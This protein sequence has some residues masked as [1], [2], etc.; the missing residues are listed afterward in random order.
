MKLKFDEKGMVKTRLKSSLPLTITQSKTKFLRLISG[1]IFWALFYS[2]FIAAF[3][4]A[5]IKNPR[6]P[7]GVITLLFFVSPIVFFFGYPVWHLK[8]NLTGWFWQF[9]ITEQA[10]VVKPLWGDSIS[11]APFDIQKY[12]TSKRFVKLKTATTQIRF[13]YRPLHLK[14]G[15]LLTAVLHEW[16]PTHLFPTETQEALNE[17]KTNTKEINSFL[18]EHCQ[19]EYGKK[20]RYLARVVS[21]IFPLLFFFLFPS[22]RKELSPLTIWG[23]LG[24]IFFL[25]L[26]IGIV[27]NL[28]LETIPAKLSV[29]SEGIQFQQW[30]KN[31]FYVWEDISAIYISWMFLHIWQESKKERKINLRFIK[32]ENDQILF[33]VV[34]KQAYARNIPNGFG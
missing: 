9:E 25:V 32:K 2:S 11:I 30:R 34:L 33:E 13:N 27:I 31:D 3:A 12:D 4:G 7:G 22:I 23:V 15:L 28:W 1:I 17:R 20:E 19:V 8:K 10:L 14:D 21:L 5:S 18:D 29:N 16:I 26:P 24:V 6:I